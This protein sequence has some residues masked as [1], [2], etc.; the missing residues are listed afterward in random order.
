LVVRLD[1]GGVTAKDRSENLSDA[2]LGR[3]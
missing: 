2:A 3:S 1:G